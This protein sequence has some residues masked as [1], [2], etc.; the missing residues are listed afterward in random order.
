MISHCSW[1]FISVG[2][3]QIR[4]PRRWENA[5]GGQGRAGE[6]KTPSRRWRRNDKHN[7][8][9]C[10]RGTYSVFLT[11]RLEKVAPHLVP[12]YFAPFSRSLAP[13]RGWGKVSPASFLNATF[14][15][16]LDPVVGLSTRGRVLTIVKK[17][18]IITIGIASPFQRSLC[19]RFSVDNPAEG[20]KASIGSRHRFGVDNANNPP[21]DELV[22]PF[23][24]G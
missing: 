21:R 17:L 13:W 10:I 16:C 9:K 14:F 1:A 2:S 22:L 24:R 6:V 11:S 7:I 4:P 8:R 23:Q 18:Y 20:R 12:L 15:F 19:R 3:C 5:C